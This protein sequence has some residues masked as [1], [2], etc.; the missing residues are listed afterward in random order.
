M[1]GVVRTQQVALTAL[2]DVIDALLA[3]DADG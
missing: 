2:A 1:A 3:D